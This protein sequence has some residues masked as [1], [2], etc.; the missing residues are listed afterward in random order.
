MVNVA[1]FIFIFGGNRMTIQDEHEIWFETHKR[2][3]R[4]ERLRRLQ[5][6]Y[7]KAERLLMEQIVYPVVGSFR[8]LHPEFEVRMLREASAYLDVA[9]VRGML[10]IDFE[11]DGFGPH[12][13]DVSRDQFAW[14]RRRDAMLRAEGWIVLRFAYDDVLEEPESIRRIV[15]RVLRRV[16]LKRGEMSLQEREV[17]KFAMLN[18]KNIIKVARLIEQ[19]EIGRDQTRALLRQMAAD[20]VLDILGDAPKHVH[21]YKLNTANERVKRMVAGL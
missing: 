6:G 11:I 1:F 18:K 7:Q 3:R 2:K 9:L 10:K 20:G 8:D 15:R 14:D 21:R 17:I 5:V 16:E 12:E 4:G 13:R 19:M